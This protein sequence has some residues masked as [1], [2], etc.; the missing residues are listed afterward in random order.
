M[1]TVKYIVIIVSV[2]CLSFSSCA[3]IVSGSSQDVTINT[4]PTAQIEITSDTGRVFY[5]GESPTVVKLPRKHTYT[6]TVK[7]GGYGNQMVLITKQFNVWFVG[8][9]LIGGIIGGVVD[10]M[11]GAMWNLQPEIV[12]ISLERSSIDKDSEIFVVLNIIDTNGENHFMKLPL[13]QL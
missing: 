10:I 11:T 8:N 6:V 5:S 12:R 3:T 7:A 13:S 9:I 1:R 4:Q 2:L